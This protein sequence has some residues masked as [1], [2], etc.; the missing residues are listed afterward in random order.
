MNEG[1]THVLQLTGILQ[2]PDGPQG[3]PGKSAYQIA[4][5][6]GFKGTE[7]EWIASLKGP[8]GDS[9]EPGK[10]Y[11][12]S[13]E[14]TALA[15][16]V[17]TDKD[18]VNE[19][20][21]YT[22][23]IVKYAESTTIQ[24]IADAG[25]SQIKR[26]HEKG[27]E[28]L[29]SIPDDFSTQMLSKLDKNQGIENAGKALIIG[30]NG[31]IEPGEVRIEVDDNGKKLIGV[32][33]GGSLK[34]YTFP[35]ES[36]RKNVSVEIYVTINEATKPAWFYGRASTSTIAF[37]Y[38]NTNK[39]IRVSTNVGNFETVETDY[40]LGEKIH[41]VSTYEYL[42]GNV[43]IRAYINGKFIGSKTGNTAPVL[44]FFD[45]F[46]NLN[47]FSISVY[48]KRV[49][50]RVITEKEVLS[51]YNNGKP[52]SYE[53]SVDL[54]SNL[55][56]DLNKDGL[57][58]HGWN[59]SISQSTIQFTNT[60]ELIY[61]NIISARDVINNEIYPDFSYDP[62]AKRNSHDCTFIND[63]FVTFSKPSDAAYSVMYINPTNWEV[64]K[65]N[66]VNFT[67]ENGREL[68]N[69]SV[70]YKFDKL[71]IGNGRA[72][73]Y[74]ETSYLEQGAKL[75]IFHDASNWRNIETSTEITFD[76]CGK[77]DI[78]DVSG[79]GFKVYG[80]WGATDNLVFVSCNL[81]DDVYLIQLGKGTNNLGN[82]VFNSTSDINRYNGSYKI[83]NRW[84]Q[85]NALKE[86]SGHG[87][88]YY[89]GSLYIATNNIDECTV[90]K[91]DLSGSGKLSFDAIKLDDYDLLNKL[92]MK[93]IDGICVK[94]GIMYAQP[95]YCNNVMVTTGIIKCE[96]KNIF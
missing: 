68:E 81:F 31:N 84:H 69:K 8:K 82:G 45:E 54:K 27:E 2:G 4:L 15:D 61:D 42:D 53:P 56:S 14:F 6:N 21:Q 49:W 13:E 16:Q 26:V 92:K 80:F 89:G 62:S 51:L 43:T 58:K 30:T 57:S 10:D 60:A 9:G 93:Y 41:I 79:L 87:G 63:E 1:K 40:N 12:H 7:Q 25:D 17:R 29:H 67:E 28:V 55:V 44:G 71:M 70:D 48:G 75:Y 36:S 83:I 50:D 95:L 23:K 3:E 18:S 38:H 33:N 91:C 86:Y 47:I 85:D 52:Q 76:N 34:S 64:V 19:S 88:Q 65:K 78:I 35:T 11:D 72:I 66:R 32:K 96:I 74:G 77:Y 22:E 37:Y 24:K 39:K 46:S 20:K 73:K 90:Y 94:D 59:D 5:D